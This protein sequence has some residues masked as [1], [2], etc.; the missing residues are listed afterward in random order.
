MSTQVE[1]PIA[2]P[3]AIAA[4]TPA[5]SRAEWLRLARWARRLS[6]ASLAYMGVEG[7]VALAAGLAAGSIALVGFGID[8]AIEGFAS[9]VIV[10]RFTGNRL[11]SEHAERRAQRLVAVQFFL[12]AP[13]IAV[14]AI[15]DLAGSEHPDASWVGIGVAIGSIVLMPA[16]GIAKQRI[17]RRMGSVATQGEGA[18]N[19]LCAYMAAALLV[20]LAGNALFGL[21][22]LDPAAALAI[23]ALA[24]REGGEAWSGDSCCMPAAGSGDDACH[25]DCCT[26]ASSR[27]ALPIAQCRLDSAG[28]RGQAGRYQR[29]GA[30]ATHIER[31]DD[32]IIATFGDLLDERLLD[33]TVAVERACC[34]FFD[35]DYRPAERRLAISVRQPDQRSALD[36]V[37]HLLARDDAA[38]GQPS[39]TAPSSIRVGPSS[40]TVP[41]TTT[42]RPNVTSPRTRSRRQ[43]MSDGGPAGKR[44]SNS[45]STLK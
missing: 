31:A 6:W 36:A 5:I 38:V 40:S 22:W 33:Q 9:L 14:Q 15:R 39:S 27:E 44:A 29:L 20:G 21:W 37:H 34:P 17:G 45:R 32:A 13:Y 42:S 10:W 25:D 19:L 12:L 24:V 7:A 11:R 28:L 30:A 41:R 3:A 1:L 8:S 4:P 18:Q 2:A 35:F 43:A 23:A 26:A 16:L